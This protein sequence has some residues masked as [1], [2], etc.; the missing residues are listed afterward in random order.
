MTLPYTYKK[1]FNELVKANQNGSNYPRAR[2]SARQEVTI[3]NVLDYLDRVVE[4]KNEIKAEL[5]I[6]KNKDKRKAVLNH[7]GSYGGNRSNPR[8]MKGG[9]GYSEVTDSDISA[10]DLNRKTFDHTKSKNL[11][12]R[13]SLMLKGQSK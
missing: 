8:S 1:R 7:T 5:K 4:E 13:T 3:G 10:S 6:I 9:T 11:R 2:A 12:E